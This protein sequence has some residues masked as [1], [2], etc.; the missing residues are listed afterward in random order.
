MNI[1]FY[2]PYISQEWGGV[3]QYACNLLEQM[4][5]Y[6]DDVHV[7]VYH[8]SSDKDILQIINPAEGLTRV[9]ESDLPF[10]NFYRAI[11]YFLKSI[12]K[13]FISTEKVENSDFFNRYNVANRL[14]KRFNIDILHS[15]YQAVPVCSNVKMIST[16]HDMQQE[17]FPDFF[18][19]KEL[20]YREK[21]YPEYLKRSD[22]VIV[23]YQHIKDDVVRLYEIPKDKVHVIL[24][25]M[26]KLWFNNIDKDA[27]LNQGRLQVPEKYILYPANTWPHKNHLNLL[28]AIL[29]LKKEKNKL[30]NVVFTGNYSNEHGEKVEKFVE[31]NGLENQ[32]FFKGI[33]GNL[34]LFSL[35]QNTR[36]VLVPTLY[37]AGSFP[38]MESIL[39]GVP[40]ICSNV[41]SLPETI[42]NDRYVFNPQDKLSIAQ[43]LELIYEDEIYRKDNIEAIALQKDRL[44]NTKAC[45]KLIRCY[46]MALAEDNQKRNEIS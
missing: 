15:P 45:E 36:A 8:K 11:T 38:L 41:T 5:E 18:T 9:D 13:I 22:L 1:L 10:N 3:K 33:V 17:Y 12:A 39:M 43:K 42:G 14:V 28:E 37:E 32:V 44:I 46:K 7:T 25:Q 29:Y 27:V 19:E 30:V 4:K 16:M 26:D 34:E 2:I 20:A 40:V 21:Y 31:E 6:P 23:S 35:Y 24:L